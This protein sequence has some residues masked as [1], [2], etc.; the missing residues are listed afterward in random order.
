M[1]PLQRQMAAAHLELIQLCLAAE[2]DPTEHAALHT[3]LDA[4]QADGWEALSQ[5][6]RQRLHPDQA[7]L[8]DTDDEDR[9]ILQLIDH[10]R[11]HPD[12][13]ASF[14]AQ[15]AE[16]NR[17]HAAQALAALIYAATQGEREALETLAELHQA[18]D[19]PAAL[20]TSAA[21]IA[22]IEGER[23]PTTLCQNLPN[24]QIALMRAVLKVLQ[25]L[26]A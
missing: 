17:L 5:T 19:T 24:D 8:P 26:E 25:E 6:L 14:A 20:A 23:N 18:S 13:F 3:Y 9:A 12:D 15:A 4:M 16:D 1:T 10:A 2:N 11:A 7:P 21:F 22:M